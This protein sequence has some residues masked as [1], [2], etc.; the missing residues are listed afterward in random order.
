[1]CQVRVHELNITRV[2]IQTEDTTSVQQKGQKATTT[3]LMGTVQ[4]YAS[5]KRK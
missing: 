5:S 3:T 4:L 1:M 2:L